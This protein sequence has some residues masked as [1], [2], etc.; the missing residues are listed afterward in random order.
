MPI[1]TERPGSNPVAPPYW[2]LVANAA[3]GRCFEHDAERKTLRELA[4]FVHPQSRLKASELGKDRPGHALKGLTSTQYEPH[5]DPLV[6][7][8]EQFARELTHYLEE[9][10]LAHRY[11]RLALLASNPF[12]GVLRAQ[13]GASSSRL[14]QAAVALDLTTIEGTE[15]ERRIAKAL[16]AAA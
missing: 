9:A 16:Q 3:R 12:L 10:A 11:A 15:L 13:L 8:H 2:V 4:S 14:L 7:E 6:K 1:Q 5:T